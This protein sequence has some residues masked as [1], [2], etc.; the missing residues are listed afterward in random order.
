MKIL[1]VS[2]YFPPDITAAAFRIYDTARLLAEAGHEVQ[3][4]TAFP[5]RSVADGSSLAEYDGQIP[6]VW[7]TRVAPLN[8]GGFLDYIKHYSSFMIGSGWLGVRR[9]LARWKPDV[10]WAS[11]P[12]LFVGLSGAAL[13]RL[14]GSP[15]V[16][17]IRDIWPASAVG[18]GQLSANGRA[19]W[20]G[21]KMEQ[22][23][24]RRA[25]HITCVARPMQE[26]ICE[27]TRTPVTVV[28]NGARACE[29]AE[30]DADAEVQ[31][32]RTLLYAG[33]L[34]RAQQLDLLIRAWANVRARGRACHWTIELLGTGALEADL[35]ELAANL[36]VSD[37]LTFSPPVARQEAM[38][39][40]VRAAA[41]YVSLRPAKAFERTIP[42]KIFDCMAAGKP[43]LA[44]VAGEA[45]TILESTGSNLC[46]EP[47]DQESLE[48]CSSKPARR[49]NELYQ[50]T[51]CQC[52][53]G[54]V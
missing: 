53:Y 9:R 2:Q 38:R 28:Y 49:A 35:R 11:S 46:C 23:V 52:S 26:Y 6:G 54:R 24:Y 36:G 47:G 27:R 44:G 7:R 21:T 45:R 20:L 31:Q 50:G 15:L 51:G 13:A 16:A 18:T 14:Y 32:D 10:I 5:H 25:S 8:G 12:P 19:Y 3:V 37:S 41:L 17:D 4:I 33:N 29:I 48:A 22:Y 39:Q 43:I 40:M 1:I 30:C 42:S 34:G